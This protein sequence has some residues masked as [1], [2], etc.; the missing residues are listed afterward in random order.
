MPAC[1]ASNPGL[2]PAPGVGPFPT[3][4]RL[5]EERMRTI[6]RPVRPRARVLWATSLLPAVAI[7][8]ASLG[9]PALAKLETWRDEGAAG[10]RKGQRHRVVVSDSGRV[11]LGHETRALGK[12]DAARVWDLARTTDGTV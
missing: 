12:F 1:R 7:V 4:S 6:A 10:W 2:V 8:A 11:R 3:P 5:T 9:A